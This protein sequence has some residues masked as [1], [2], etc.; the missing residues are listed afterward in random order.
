[1]AALAYL[2]ENVARL[3]VN[4]SQLLIAGDS[5]GAQI[6]AQVAT[7]VTSNAFAEKV[8]V[9]P[10]IAPAQLRGVALFCG[11][12]DLALIR[13]DS[14]FKDFFT[15]VLWAYSGTRRFRDDPYFFPTMSVV[16]HV[17]E[18][19]PPTFITVGNADGLAPHST[20]LAEALRAKGVEVET[21]FYPPDHLPALGHEYQFKIEL[22]DAQT[23]LDRLA[24]FFH[25]QTK[26][27]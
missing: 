5:A 6:T 23:A 22:D 15:A 19:F 9:A 26:S 17:T 20:A 21:L 18:A 25:R 3:H 16:H 11:P 10:T 2:Q 24:A 4:P 7:C 13:E 27:V 8:R 1:M 14:A 12:Y